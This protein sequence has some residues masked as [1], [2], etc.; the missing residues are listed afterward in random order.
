MTNERCQCPCQCSVQQ[1]DGVCYRDSLG[2][3]HLRTMV[4]RCDSEARTRCEGM[5]RDLLRR[6]AFEGG[7]VVTVR[8]VEV[9][10]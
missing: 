5:A 2:V 8:L 10:E 1:L 7:K 4:P 9:G 6:Q 3:L